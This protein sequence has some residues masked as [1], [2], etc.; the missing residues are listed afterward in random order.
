MSGNGSSD[1]V[2]DADFVEQDVKTAARLSKTGSSAM[3]LRIVNY[4][5]CFRAAELPGLNQY[6]KVPYGVTRVSFFPWWLS[7]RPMTLA[8]TSKALAW[9]MTLSAASS[10]QYISMR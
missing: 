8:S 9:A 2:S 1:I 10:G 7:T 4:V 5:M 6:S 3:V